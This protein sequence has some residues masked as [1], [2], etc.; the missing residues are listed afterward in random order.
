MKLSNTSNH[1]LSA[2]RGGGSRALDDQNAA[3]GRGMPQQ[4][5]VYVIDDSANKGYSSNMPRTQDDDTHQRTGYKYKGESSWS[6]PPP[7]E[8]D[9][10]VFHAKQADNAAKQIHQFSGTIN[11]GFTI[12]EVK[13][14]D[15]NVYVLL[16]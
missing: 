4:A 3:R 13:H 6:A 11:L 1:I 15:L 9:A 10:T 7:K 12:N 2:S 8:S 14:N 5:I 16:K